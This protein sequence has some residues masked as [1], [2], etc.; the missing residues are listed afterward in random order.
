[1]AQVGEKENSRTIDA[2]MVKITTGASFAGAIMYDHGML[3]KEQEY[4]VIGYEGLDLEYDS[5]GRLAT[6]VQDVARS[7]EIQASLNQ[8]VFNPVKHFAISW[9]PDDASRLTNEVMMRAVRSYLNEMGYDN[10]QY[11]VIRHY[12]TDNPHCHVVVNAVDNN[13]K[14][15][16]DYM[17]RKRSVSVCQKITKEM[18]FTWGCHKSANQSQIPHDSRQR[19]YE[20]ARYEI[21]QI[22]A[23]AIPQVRSIKELPAVLMTKY[24]VTIDLKLDGKGN[25]CGISFSKQVRDESGKM[26]TCRFSGSKIDRKFSCHGLEKIINVW[27]RFPSLRAEAQNIL[28]IHSI[29]KD[30]HVIP[31]KVQQQCRDLGWQMW[32]LG[33]EEQKLQRSLPKSIAKGALETMLAISFMDPIGALVAVLSVSL[34]IAFKNNKLEKIRDQRASLAQDIKDIKQTFRQEQILGQPQQQ[35]QSRGIKM[36]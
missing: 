1:M 25:P 31:Q 36:K 14:K 8:K 3:G 35:T 23:S 33:R 30:T 27:H 10:T 32:R 34:V 11:L 19:T 26:V 12:G 18:D 15:I 24:G 9:P 4:E 7:F 21:A 29:I 17:E 2:M 6:N 5:E 20:S 22:I 13:G 16:N 28:N